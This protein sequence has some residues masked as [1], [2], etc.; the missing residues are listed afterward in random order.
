M[1]NSIGTSG[2]TVKTYSELLSQMVAAYQAIYG[3]DI[4]LDSSTPDG[5]LLN[6]F[7]QAILDQED[8][9]VQINNNFDPDLAFGTILDQRVALNGIQRKAG[10]HTITNINITTTQALTLQGLDLFPSNPYTVADSQGN[11]F[12]LITTQ[13][14]ASAGVYT[15]SFQAS[16]PGE[17]LTVPN[18]ITVPVSVVLGVSNINNPSAYTSLGLNEE[19]DGQ[20]RLRRQQSVSIGSQ[21]YL[22]GLLAALNNINGV[23]T[24]QVYE[25]VT[26]ITDSYGL[27]SHS[28]N[29]VI[30]GAVA[31]I[32]VASAI[33]QKRN[34]GCGMYG[35][36]SYTITQVDGS[37]FTVKWDVVTPLPLYIKFN[38]TSIDG[39][40]A[41]LATQIKNKL[42][43][44]WV[45][46]VAQT[47]DITELG[48][49]VQQ[50]DPNSL[51]TV[52]AGSQG[53]SLTGTGGWANVLNTTLRNNQF[54]LSSANITITVI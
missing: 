17:V 16:A 9:L 22:A 27:P 15:Y 38:V 49:Y 32:D 6:I 52:T 44:I 43:S 4:N 21:G 5:Q 48:T 2:L 28:I 35:A 3:T 47:V 53:F 40:N 12:Q 11:Q 23:T 20:L 1:P 50:I 31:P 18:S 24:A 39:I 30:G 13:Y 45:P 25:N 26:D 34:A 33:Y 19:T 54:A 51:V 41:P 37:F 29:V 14:P 7:I 46:G 10:T 8:L 36:Q 42:P